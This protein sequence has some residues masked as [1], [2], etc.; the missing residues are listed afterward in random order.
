LIT[1]DIGE[2]IS[3]LTREFFR[4]NSIVDSL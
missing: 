3:I 4:A 1:L 2:V